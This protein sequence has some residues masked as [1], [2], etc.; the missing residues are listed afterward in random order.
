MTVASAGRQSRADHGTS[1]GAAV[2]AVAAAFGAYFCMYAFR[3]PYTAAAFSGEY[4]GIGFKTL[5]VTSQVIGYAISKFMGIRIVAATAWGDRVRRFLTLIALAEISLLLFAVLPRP[6][7][8]IGLFCNGLALGM[9]FGM[10]LGFL[11]GRRMTEALSAGLCASFILADGVTKSVGAWLLA[12]G[13]TEAWMPFTA[14]LLFLAPVCV[15]AAML[16]RIP[17]PTEA[18]QRA[19]SERIPMTA[20]VRSFGVMAS[21]SALWWRCT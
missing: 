15:F 17:R 21:G 2:W 20:A 18:D 4:A 7:A 1:V 12:R 5:L 6:L 8:A 13:V 9:V 16:G 3:R 14:G 11:E 10:V 19:R